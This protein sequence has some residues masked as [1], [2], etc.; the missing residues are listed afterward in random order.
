MK[1]HIRQR[2][3][4]SFELKFDAGRDPAT[5][6]RRIQYASFKGTKREAQIKLA[7][8]IT[9]VG[10]G[11]YVEPSKST[12]AEFVRG[13][14]DQWQAAG[15]ISART[16]QR[17]RQL[18]ENQIAPHIGS[19]VLQKLSRLDIEGWHNALQGGLAAR[20]IGHAHRVL[21][22][23]LSDAESDGLVVRNVC[24]L[25]KAPKVAESEM[26]IAQDVPGLVAK[27]RGSR[28]YV[29]AMVALFT[30]MRLGEVLALR[31]G[32]VDLDSKVVQVREALEPTKAGIRFKAPKSKAGR[33][34]ITLPDLLVDTL[35]EHRRAAL[36]FRMQLGAGRLPDDA[37]LFAN[38]DGDPLQP[39]N[40]SSD[41]GDLA[42]RL[43]IPDV[44]FHGLR[45]THASQL[46]A[47]D[48]DIVTVSKRLG[49]AKPSVTLAIY[50]HMFHTD[51]SKA[52]AAINATLG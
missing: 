15:D 17:Y 48:V 11:S 21:S 43:G 19:K 51:D 44:T 9:S 24:K 45:H 18:V 37:L 16:A 52:A 7:A 31:W 27:L 32:R 26:A 36:E 28:L 5:G 35:R 23:A 40:V 41:W 30:G 10:A 42:E 2:G 49:H 12:V 8:L 39:S 47:S 4:N 34:D 3:R 46:I 14:V 1:G 50:A 33:R 13:R 25:R 29:P 38:L 6:K 22:K 20:T